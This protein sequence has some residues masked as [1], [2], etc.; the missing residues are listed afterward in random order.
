MQV[1]F[2]FCLVAGGAGFL[3]SLRNLVSVDTGFNPKG[4]TVL[5]MTSMAQRDRQLPLMQQIQ[6]RTATLARVQGAATAW[7]AV[8]SGARRA[9]RVVLPGKAPS[10]QEEIFYRV[11]PGYFRTLHTPLLSGRDFTF[12]DNDD[13]PIPTVV[14]RAFARKYFGGESLLGREFRRDDGIR[15][16]IVGVA[17]DSHFR[18]LR[19]GPEPIAYMPMKPPRAFTMYVRSTLDAVSVSKMVEREA[20]ALGSGLRIRDVTT[21]ETLVGNTVRTERLLAGIGG[22]FALLGLI[23]A[24]TGLFGLLNYSVTRR[25]RE[26][27]IRTVLGAQRLS[28]YGLVLKDLSATMAGGLMAGMA[29]ALALM[30]FVQSLL[31]GIEPVDPLVIG[32]TMAV[33]IGAA[34][35]AGGPPA[36][37]AA[38]IDPATALRND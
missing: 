12:R 3:F 9:Q 14:N 31:F 32:T 1:A 10:E 4:I 34:L 36:H 15:H 37:R 25:T 6:M 11:S 24:A 19:Q 7:M 17:A 26:I 8:F 22:A 38:A 29:G 27:G 23:L 35:L 33:F 16:Q 30:R 18:S 2:A 28:I 13:E 20:Q 5:S 21:L